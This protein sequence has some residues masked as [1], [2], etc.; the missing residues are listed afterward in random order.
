MG[1]NTKQ[2]YQVSDTTLEAEW[3]RI[4]FGNYYQCTNCKHSISHGYPAQS[5][6]LGKFC[7][8]CGFKMRNPRFIAVEYDYD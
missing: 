5:I 2:N 4:P 3:I 8:N 1:E 6:R 7:P